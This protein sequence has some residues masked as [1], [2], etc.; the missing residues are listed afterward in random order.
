MMHKRDEE[1]EKMKRW[2]LLPEAR[3][4]RVLFVVVLV[5]VVLLLFRWVF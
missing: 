3:S 1:L 2:R 5:I 4:H